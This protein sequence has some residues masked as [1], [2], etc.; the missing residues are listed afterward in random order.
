MNKEDSA[1]DEEKDRRREESRLSSNWGDT[2]Q[3]RSIEDFRFDSL[4]RKGSMLSEDFEI[5]QKDYQD[6]ELVST[7]VEDVAIATKRGLDKAGEWLV[8]LHQQDVMTIGDM[9]ELDDEDWPNLYFC[10]FNV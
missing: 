7:L 2:L 9:R 10:N 6:E 8:K 5:P 3:R 1:A 4:S